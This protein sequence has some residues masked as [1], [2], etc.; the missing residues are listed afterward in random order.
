[1]TLK[2][3]MRPPWAVASMVRECIVSSNEF[4][5][6]ELTERALARLFNLFSEAFDPL[7]DNV[8]SILTPIVYEQFPYQQSH[9]EE[10]LRSIA[11]LEDDYVGART[12]PWSDVLGA[13]IA[14]MVT[15]SFIIH[16]VTMR[17]EGEYRTRSDLGFPEVVEILGL[18]EA[19]NAVVH[20]LTRTI[21]E[22]KAAAL[23]VPLSSSSHR[24]FAY[25]PLLRTPLVATNEGVFAPVP[26]LIYDSVAPAVLYHRGR[27]AWGG[28]FTRD[29]GLRVEQYVGRQLR[30]GVPHY[31]L[32]PEIRYDN[33]QLSADWFMM[34]DDTLVIVECKA[35]RASLD[36]RLGQEALDAQ[37][38][39]DILKA[40]RQIE[41]SADL[42]TSGH[43]SFAPLAGGRQVIG[44]IITAEPFY[45]LS[46]SHSNLL[47]SGTPTLLGSLRDLEHLMTLDGPEAMEQLRAI[48]SDPEKRTWPLGNA[49]DTPP[50]SVAHNPILESVWDRLPLARPVAQRIASQ[51]AAS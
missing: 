26:E 34:S 32:I 16:T 47:A 7:G 42:V 5:R 45:L 40:K 33:G 17:S 25:N 30:L 28:A 3:A 50:N 48:A 35:A 24:R 27:D 18:T 22:L 13:S 8:Q 41:R 46:L 51:K 10:I 15:A 23:S 39:R 4:R 37:F 29:L 11:L 49:L 9:Y 20:G 19:L 2:P 21:P 31:E 6:G 36:A 38:E 44:L 14:D 43:Q 12:W 1:M